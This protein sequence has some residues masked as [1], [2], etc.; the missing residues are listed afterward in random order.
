MYLTKV[1]HADGFSRL[2]AVKLLHPRWS[3]NEEIASRMRD[4][5]RLLGW[6]RHKNI[7][8][9]MDLT[10]IDGRCAVIMEYLDAVDTKM[11]I[12]HCAETE[13]RI[14]LRPALEMCAAVASALDAAYNRPPYA[15]EKPL[16]V[17]HRDIKPSNIMVDDSGVVKVLDF[18]VARAEFDERESKTQEIA[19]GSLEY[20][21]P[22]RLFFEPESPASDVY[23]LGATLYELLAL[24]K[25]GKA[26]LRPK[27]HEAFFEDRF[28]VLLDRYPM[29]REAEDL[30]HELLMSM[31][32]F[33][34]PDR[35]TAAD[36][37]AKMRSFARRLTDT[38]L[39]EWSEATVPQLL[40]A[41]RERTEEATPGSLV[42][43]ILTEDA[44]ALDQRSIWDENTG[45]ST[46]AL[47]LTA[48]DDELTGSLADDARWKALKQATIE[49][50]AKRGELPRGVEAEPSPR[51]EPPAEVPEPPPPRPL[52]PLPV[53]GN[54]PPPVEEPEDPDQ[55]E[56]VVDAPTLDADQLPP[57][58]PVDVPDTVPEPDPATDGP[59]GLL[60]TVVVMFFAGSGV[61]LIGVALVMLGL[62]ISMMG[63]E[64]ANTP[65]V[66]PQPVV[67]PEPVEAPAPPSPE[68]AAPEPA[69]PAEPA[70]PPEP[71]A[72]AG[73]AVQFSSA[74]SNTKVLNVSCESGRQ[75]GVDS[76]R[77]EGD[78][79]GVC[80]VA[81]ILHDGTRLRTKVDD[82]EPRE[83][84]CFV[85][86]ST[87]C[88]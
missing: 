35:P 64:T 36:A 50:M 73:P 42:D 59:S 87:D 57:P 80:R 63:S 39:E 30:L 54:L 74:R 10:L 66:A 51:P 75:K 29:H 21:P 58:A 28:D 48:L 24:E 26:K 84:V 67:A 71:A 43:T 22:E 53:P 83:Y 85:G 2:V 56:T 15:G 9:V 65:V 12:N 62:A 34:E 72:P 31:L 81:A 88:R 82:V 6:L 14:P 20:M 4:E 47:D 23:S 52:E 18:G 32:A 60:A 77:I 16:R 69:P 33:E 38:P 17:I 7:V 79:H 68:P 44:K 55:S 37:V 86:D 45:A 49:D 19:F 78:Q 76:V 27:E 5:A 46:R 70:A 61:A 3:E 25:F 8:D 11:L 41:T 13:Q 1:I 40:K